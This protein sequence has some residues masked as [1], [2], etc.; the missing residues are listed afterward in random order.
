MDS[1]EYEVAACAGFI[2]GLGGD[3]DTIQARREQMDVAQLRWQQYRERK[4]D[5]NHSRILTLLHGD[6]KRK[7][8]T[9]IGCLRTEYQ[10]P[11]LE[12]L[13]HD[14]ILKHAKAQHD[15][16]DVGKKAKPPG[17]P[18][19]KE[20]V[21]A[22]L[23][24]KLT[25]DREAILE[26]QQ[27]SE[28]ME[29]FEE[30]TRV[31]LQQRGVRHV[32]EPGLV[33]V[34]AYYDEPELQECRRACIQ[35]RTKF[36]KGSFVITRYFQAL[37]VLP[38]VTDKERA[39]GVNVKER[40]RREL[41]NLCTQFGSQHSAVLQNIRVGANGISLDEEYF[42][43]NF[44]SMSI[45]ARDSGETWDRQCTAGVWFRTKEHIV[46]APTGSYGYRRLDKDVQWKFI[47]LHMGMEIF[48]MV[49]NHKSDVEVQTN[50]Q[51]KRDYTLV[52]LP[53]QISPDILK[54]Q[55]HAQLLGVWRGCHGLAENANILGTEILA[56]REFLE[57]QGF[58][59]ESI[60]WLADRIWHAFDKFDAPVPR[61]TSKFSQTN[62]GEVQDGD[63]RRAGEK[64]KD[65]SGKRKSE[66]VLKFYYI[67]NRV[68]RTVQAITV[69]RFYEMMGN[70]RDFGHRGFRMEYFREYAGMYTTPVHSNFVDT[71]HTT[72]ISGVK[73]FVFADELLNMA[74][75]DTG[76]WN[77]MNRVGTV[78]YTN[79]LEIRFGNS[80]RPE[81]S[82][83]IIFWESSQADGETSDK[84]GQSIWPFNITVL[85][86]DFTGNVGAGLQVSNDDLRTDFLNLGR[87]FAGNAK[88]VRSP[89]SPST[90]QSP[91]PKKV[92][93]S[94][95]PSAMT[96]YTPQSSRSG[97]TVNSSVTS[98][99]SVRTPLDPSLMEL[100]SRMDALEKDR[101][102]HNDRLATLEQKMTK[103]SNSSLDTVL[104][105][106]KE[107]VSQVM[108]CQDSVQL[109]Q[110]K[111]SRC[112]TE[113][114]KAD[115]EDKLE[116]ENKKLTR[117]RETLQGLRQEAQKL[118]SDL[119]VTLTADDLGL[120]VA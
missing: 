1:A 37:G 21:K 113:E 19:L 61:N 11:K 70:K 4:L 99:L 10:G 23:P 40:V 116:L 108:N 64:D 62:R 45:P 51:W 3:A 119:S 110:K 69:D 42:D 66:M 32:F 15:W 85:R 82:R 109:C 118:A 80:V 50:G 76:N 98:E 60:Y 65:K 8:N 43:A 63:G 30:A 95:L 111:L 6:A 67:D 44:H 13:L 31:Q 83:L 59:S 5:E 16:I 87:L 9:E 58:P 112:K 117:Q 47:G 38:N 22:R 72:V 91:T 2:V 28:A 7:A 53:D 20:A 41:K 57:M 92:K 103:I 54:N 52:A 29:L 81:Y 77:N 48:D 89:K 107:G 12:E 55:T 39:Q 26:L 75:L 94:P 14:A 114:S 74:L 68:D 90:T 106:I 88:S 104:R 27:D 79:E 17:P 84:K 35:D 101:G 18:K 115:A 78:V 86:K 71:T 100:F 49:Q 93:Q 25:G 73:E 33:P 97:S 120:D 56:I 102:A 105:A 46:T 36:D 24:V 34:A 96:I